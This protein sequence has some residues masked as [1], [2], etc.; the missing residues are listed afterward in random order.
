MKV[1]GTYTYTG[2]AQTPTAGDVV[3]T[4]GGRTV[5]SDQYTISASD[6]MNAGQATATVTAKAGGN[7]TG[8]ASGKFT[9]EMADPTYTTTTGGRATARGTA[10][11]AAGFLHRCQRNGCLG[12]GVFGICGLDRFDLNFADASYRNLTVGIHCCGAA[13]D[14]PCDRPCT[15]T[16]GGRQGK[17]V[18]VVDGS[19]LAGDGKSRLLCLTHGK[20]IGF[21]RFSAIA[22]GDSFSSGGGSS[23]GSGSSSDNGDSSGSTVVERPDQTKPERTHKRL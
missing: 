7:Y 5:P 18:P 1:N 4:L 3:V 10:P 17:G 23:S 12:L 19:G 16:A 13:D 8:S 15:G 14:L 21:G 2:Q 6:N 9:I 22:D 20:C 11:A